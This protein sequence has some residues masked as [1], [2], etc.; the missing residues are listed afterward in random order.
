VWL[1][2][3]NALNH[4]QF[5]GVNSTANFAGPGSTAITNLPFKADGTL[6]NINGFGTVNSVRPPR[7]LQLSARFQF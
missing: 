2:A 1:D 6:Q 3:F 7:N 5:N 4:I